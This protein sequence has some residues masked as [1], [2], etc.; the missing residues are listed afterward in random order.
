MAG[1][2]DEDGSSWGGLDG[3]ESDAGCCCCRCGDVRTESVG[4]EGGGQFR[5]GKTS[6]CDEWGDSPEGKK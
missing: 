6:T 1:L 5:L 2:L 4:G 3:E